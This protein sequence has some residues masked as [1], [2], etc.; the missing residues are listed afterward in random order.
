MLLAQPFYC[1]TERVQ[2]RPVPPAVSI[3]HAAGV[4][5][6]SILRIDFFH[7]LAVHRVFEISK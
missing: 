2:A 7:L 3:Q 5:I 6:L 1:R 4:P